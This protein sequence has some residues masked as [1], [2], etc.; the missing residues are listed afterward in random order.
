MAA[1]RLLPLSPSSFFR[2]YKKTTSVSS[3]S[4]LLHT[5]PI[6]T[7]LPRLQFRS[8]TSSSAK[9]IDNASDT[10]TVGPT[11]HPW[12]EWPTF[13]DR[14]KSKGYF[15]EAPPSTAEMDDGG[16]STVDPASSDFNS[17]KSACLSFARQRFDILKSLSKKDIQAIV[18]CGCPNLFRKTVNSAKRLRAYVKLDEGDVCSACHLRGSCD[19]AYATTKDDEG[20][21]TV[22]IV[23]ILLSYAID[24]L[25]LSEG[26]KSHVRETVEASSRKLLCEL[27]ELNDTSPDPNL[28]KRAVKSSHQKVTEHDKQSQNVEMKRGDWI[29]PKCNFMNFS[30]NIKCLECKEDGPKRV[31][32]DEVEM[33]K[34]D[35]T[36]PQ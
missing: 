27:I 35:W 20:A 23:R 4:L 14:L 24:P 33:K 7:S 2:I 32:F 26:D 3:H 9:A 16:I 5:F 12:P 21:R 13:L 17:V 36:C 30:R 25:I 29:C 31:S 8:A 28:P 15:D 22:D 11:S 19:R 1:S 18:E 34:G 6:K 10:T